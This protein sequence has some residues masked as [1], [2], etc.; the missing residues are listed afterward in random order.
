MHDFRLPALVTLGVVVLLF[1]LVANVGRA[2]GKYGINAP[3][4]TGNADF[5][6]VFRVQM[7]TLESALMFLPALWI[8]SAFVSEI[9]AAA[10]GVVWLAARIWYSIAY[11]NAAARRGPPFGLSVLVIVALT[12]GGAWGVLRTLL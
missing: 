9:W 7:N 8:F 6:R 1:L 4:T 3:A 5:E 12:L 11:S 10:L 2:R